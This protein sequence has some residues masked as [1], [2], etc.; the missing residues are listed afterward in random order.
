[1]FDD[2]VYREL[3]ITKCEHQMKVVFLLSKVSNAHCGVYDYT[4][5]LCE[6]FEKENIECEIRT[7]ERWTLKAARTLRQAD[8]GR[9]DIIYHLQFPSLGMGRSLAPGLLP[10]LLWGAPFYVTLHEFSVLNI[11]RRLT[12]VLHSLL[13]HG[14]L[15]SNQQERDQFLKLFPYCKHKTSIVPIGINIKSNPGSTT[16]ISS[17]AKLV[18]FGQIYTGK[19]IEFFIETVR[20]LRQSSID[21][22]PLIMGSRVSPDGGIGEIVSNASKELD[23]VLR[24]DLSQAEVSQELDEASYALLHFPDGV[25]DKRGSALACLDHDLT[26]ITKHTSLTPTWLSTC[27]FNVASPDDASKLIQGLLSGKQEKTL[28]PELRT[29]ELKKRDW[30]NIAR[31]HQETYRLRTS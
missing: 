7:V 19:G 24:Y 4:E 1:V 5:K 18:Y 29:Q 10:I 26:V 6:A 15:F 12:F 20:R 31:S 25:S 16:L 3:M 23:I 17:P 8:K 22:T 13:A 9:S 30:V 14:I 2:Y 21:F 28:A 27:T 11:L